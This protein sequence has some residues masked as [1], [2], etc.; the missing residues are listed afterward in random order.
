MA[1][2]PG[3]P[4]AFRAAVLFQPV[5]EDQAQTVIVGVATNPLFRLVDVKKDGVPAA[6]SALLSSR[7][8]GHWAKD[9]GILHRGVA[10]LAKCP[11]ELDRHLPA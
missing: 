7:A 1:N 8:D 6:S 11:D 9:R 4:L 10:G 5:G 2:G 3:V